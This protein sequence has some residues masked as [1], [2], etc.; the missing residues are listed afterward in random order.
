[1]DSGVDADGK[2]F[3]ASL[4]L[5]IWGWV[6]VRGGGSWFLNWTHGGDDSMIVR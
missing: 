6:C 1:M 5:G 3:E 4:W 2:L